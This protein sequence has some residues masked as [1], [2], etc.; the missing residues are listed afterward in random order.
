MTVG[1]RVPGFSGL[2]VALAAS[3]VLLARGPHRST[4]S[5]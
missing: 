5:A 3:G 1:S 2:A 4:A